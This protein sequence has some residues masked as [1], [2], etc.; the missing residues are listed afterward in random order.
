MK[1]GCMFA[2][3]KNDNVKSEKVQLQNHVFR[4]LKKFNIFL[5][6]IQKTLYR[7]KKGF[8]FAAR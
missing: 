8:I 3:A 7:I 2:A 6:I 1:K 4:V 5:K